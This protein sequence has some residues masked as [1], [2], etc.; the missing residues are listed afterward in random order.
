[1]QGCERTRPH[2]CQSRDTY[3]EIA[4]APKTAIYITISRCLSWSSQLSGLQQA[5]NGGSSG[6]WRFVDREPVGDNF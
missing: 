4:H 1:M 6:A 5:V 3:L 2:S